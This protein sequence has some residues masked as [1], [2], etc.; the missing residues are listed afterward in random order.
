MGHVRVPLRITNPEN[1][2]KT[3]L[4]QSALVDTGATWTS[5]P[6]QV[7]ADLELNPVGT[8][9]VPT[10]AGPQELEQSYARL[11]LAGQHVVT[12]ISISDTLD[13]VLIGVTTLGSLG[14]AVDPVKGELVETE[15]FLL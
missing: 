11:E 4:V 5:V 14:L 10:A 3:V 12:N 1:P 2:E 13:T 9:R 8:I 6:R 7:I 15:L